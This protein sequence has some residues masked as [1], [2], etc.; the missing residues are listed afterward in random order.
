VESRTVF[1][2]NGHCRCSF[3]RAEAFLDVHCL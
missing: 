1:T 3:N 2:G